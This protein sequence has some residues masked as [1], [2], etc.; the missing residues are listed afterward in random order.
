MRSNKL[1]L[2]VLVSLSF[3]SLTACK[4]GGD[5]NNTTSIR[6]SRSGG[7][8]D[9][10]TGTQ[11][12]TQAGAKTSTTSGAQS[13]DTKAILDTNGENGEG[14]IVGGKP[15]TKITCSGIEEKAKA[16]GWKINSVEVAESKGSAKKLKI[17]YYTLEKSNEMANPVI[18]FNRNAFQNAT[19]NDLE[20]LAKVAAD[21]KLDLVLMDMRGA[22]CSTALP[23]IKTKTSELNNYSSKYAVSDAE[24][25]RKIV[26]KNSQEKKWKIMAHQSGGIVALRYVQLFPESVRSLHIADFYPSKDQ[27]KLYKL[28]IEKESEIWKVLADQEKVTEN[29][30]AKAMKNL[31]DS[32]CTGLTSCKTLIDLL[33]GSKISYKPSW[34]TIATQIKALAEDKSKTSEMMKE[35]EA[36]KASNDKIFA[37]RILDIDSDKSLSACANVLKTDSKGAINSCRLEVELRKGETVALK[38]LNHDALN[39]SLIKQNITKNEI[40][41]HLFAGQNSTLYP[42]DGYKDHEDEMGDILKNT[43]E[44]VDDGSEVYLNTNFLKTLQ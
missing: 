4:Q 32:K 11:S 5:K 2:G 12:G 20:K 30:F 19:P 37:A 40:E 38:S 1:I 42:S 43:S 26:L 9:K 27:T 29:I 13:V 39:M 28:R 34:S 24:E 16:N 7:T 6:K 41:Y 15:K 18:Y 3:L 8:S 44:I 14:A 23:D 17:A 36:R 33:G 35:F 10:N 22:G 31:D 25:V 21:Y